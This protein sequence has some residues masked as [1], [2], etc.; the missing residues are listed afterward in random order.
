MSFW[1]RIDKATEQFRRIDVE[2]QV[3]DF[4]AR[5][6]EEEHQSEEEEQIVSRDLG[7]NKCDIAENNIEIGSWDDVQRE[8]N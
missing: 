4:I 3:V 8:P 6:S 7:R 1:N 5:G 2:E